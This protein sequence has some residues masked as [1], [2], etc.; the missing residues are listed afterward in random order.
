MDIITMNKEEKNLLLLQFFGSSFPVGGFQHSY[1]LETYIAGGKIASAK[2]LTEY[3]KSV[4]RQNYVSFDGRAFCKA[5]HLM[6]QGREEELRTLDA[7]LTAMRLSKENRIASLKTGKAL[8]RMSAAI[9]GDERLKR[10]LTMTGQERRLG[11]YCIVA[12]CL[13]G[14]TDIPLKQALEAFFYSDLNNLLQ[15]GIKTIPLGQTEG[16][17]LLYTLYSEIAASVDATMADW[18]EELENF[19]PYQSLMSMQHEELY[20]RLYMS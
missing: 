1:G 15:V 18:E 2:E 6:Q 20:S 7:E 11:N 12:G 8:L 16:Q 5:Y 10:Y 9:I 3:L 4:M 17:T 19:V 14:M 13:S